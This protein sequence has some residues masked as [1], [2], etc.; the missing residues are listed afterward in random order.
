M[1]NYRLSDLLI[2]AV[3]NDI[4][5]KI[6]LYDAVDVFSKMKNRRYPFSV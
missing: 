1:G 5:A 4:A 2:I 6:S 3:E